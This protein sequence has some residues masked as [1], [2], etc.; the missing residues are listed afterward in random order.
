MVG[1][2]K[3]CR[4]VIVVPDGLESVWQKTCV[5]E[6][7]EKKVEFEADPGIGLAVKSNF[8]WAGLVH[9]MAWTYTDKL[10]ALEHTLKQTL[11]PEK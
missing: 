1:W 8:P 5:N 2:E 4:E 6:D 7:V 9:A 11:D 3:A 10:K